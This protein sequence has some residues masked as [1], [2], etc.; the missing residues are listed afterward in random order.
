MN[1][2]LNKSVTLIE[3][4][5]AVSIFALIVVGFSNI[6]TFSRYHVITSDKRAK[7]QNDAS[8]VLEH[9]AK[10]IGQAIGDV[11]QAAVNTLI[12]A[13]NTAIQAWIDYNQNGKRDSYPTDRQIAYIFTD[14]IGN[15]NERYQIWYCPECTTNPCTQC[16]PAW[17]SNENILSK[18]VNN[19][20]ATYSSTDN[21]VLIDITACYEPDGSP[22][23]CGSLDNPALSMKNRISM[24]TVSTH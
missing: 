7:L 18:K 24:P 4:L 6:D 19:F 1:P 12:I 9:M 11:N 8:F 2:R 10:T 21:H 20:S 5:I 17:G 16:N 22:F 15:V 23:D 3:L 14:G 13:G